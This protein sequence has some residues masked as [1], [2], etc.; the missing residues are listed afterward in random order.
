MTRSEGGEGVG[1]GGEKV[2]GKKKGSGDAG[3]ERSENVE[4]EVKRWAGR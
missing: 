2:E 3:R 4:E 1:G